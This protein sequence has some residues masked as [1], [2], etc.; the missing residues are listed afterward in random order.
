M[1]LFNVENPFQSY[2]DFL[3]MWVILSGV[4]T[5]KNDV[6]AARVHTFHDL[7]HYCFSFH[8]PPLLHI[9]P[10]YEPDPVINPPVQEPPTPPIHEPPPCHPPVQVPP[11][12]A[13]QPPEVTYPPPPLPTYQPAQVTQP[14]PPATCNL[15]GNPGCSPNHNPPK[16]TKSRLSISTDRK[17]TYTTMSAADPPASNRS[18]TTTLQLPSKGYPPTPTYGQPLSP[19]W[20]PTY[21]PPTHIH[22]HHLP[23][24]KP[25]A[26][27]IYQPYPG[28]LPPSSSEKQPPNQPPVC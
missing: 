20:L 27:P 22:H 10:I 4:L 7:M 18:A 8:W 6:V 16:I 26:I 17:T 19:P 3:A 21:H 1:R 23:R 13:N 9:P 24:N 28:L 2:F 12:P 5:Q 11:T 15:P 14:S 25:P